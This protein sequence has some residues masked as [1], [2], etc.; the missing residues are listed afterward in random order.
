MAN[1]ALR[2]EAG[3]TTGAPTCGARAVACPQCEAQLL[4]HRSAAPA[5]D[6]SGFETCR[7]ECT[8]CGVSLAGVVD[9]YDDA[10]LLSAL[11][12]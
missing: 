6:S 5:L 10:V 1:S 11:P 2:L 4:W 12:S 8:H 3:E 7:L 9:P